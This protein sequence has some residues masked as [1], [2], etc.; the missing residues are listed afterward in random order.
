[1]IPTRTM[2]VPQQVLL[3][4]GHPTLADQLAVNVPLS[5]HNCRTNVDFAVLPISGYDAI[6]GMSWLQQVSKSNY[7]LENSTSTC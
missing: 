3:A 4:D 2:D 7:R 1:M 6:L 5:V